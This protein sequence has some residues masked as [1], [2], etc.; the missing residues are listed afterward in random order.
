MRYQFK[1]THTIGRRARECNLALAVID[2]SAIENE[3]PPPIALEGH[4]YPGN[5]DSSFLAM[6]W[7]SLWSSSTAGELTLRL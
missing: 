1:S 5:F 3:S 7:W 2:M 4:S 6:I